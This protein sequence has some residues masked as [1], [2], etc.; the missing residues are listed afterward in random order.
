MKS[1]R[2]YSRDRQYD[3]EDICLVNDNAENL[4]FKGRRVGGQVVSFDDGILDLSL[5]Q[6]QSSEIV[7][8][9]RYSKGRTRAHRS[10]QFASRQEA[11]AYLS[12]LISL[13]KDQNHQKFWNYLR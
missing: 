8:E 7:V 4:C 1:K 3:F 6:T 13:F 12:Q 10:F 9:L 11:G 2:H 5:Y